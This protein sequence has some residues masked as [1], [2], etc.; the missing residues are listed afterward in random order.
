MPQLIDRRDVLFV[1]MAASVAVAAGTASARATEIRGIVRFEDGGPIPQGRL[2]IRPEDPA[3]RDAERPDP[4]TLPVES[5]GK[6]EAI[7]F[8][9]SLPEDWTGSPTLQ[10][11]V[12]LERADGWLLAR[13]SAQLGTNSPLEVTLYPAVY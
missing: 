6:S 3:Y 5:N 8:A 10:I 13:G 4:T 7:D 11:V 1:A 9:L 12:R 2:E